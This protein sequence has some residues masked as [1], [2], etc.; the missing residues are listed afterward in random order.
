MKKRYIIEVSGTPDE[1]Q[2]MEIEQD[3]EQVIEDIN[4]HPEYENV[5][6]T[7]VEEDAF[8]DGVI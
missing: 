1:E 7:L 6:A 8:D 3:L 2:I 5:E 4:N